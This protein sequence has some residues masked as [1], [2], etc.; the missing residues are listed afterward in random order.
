VSNFHA[1]K[2][3]TERLKCKPDDSD[4]WEEGYAT[5]GIH[6]NQMGR[7]KIDEGHRR[8]RKILVTT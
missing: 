5:Y 4:G 6:Y 3:T 7:K 1:K 2:F 8:K